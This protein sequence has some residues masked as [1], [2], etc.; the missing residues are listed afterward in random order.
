M[1]QLIAISSPKYCII[2]IKSIIYRLKS[3][4]FGK[5][6]ITSFFHLFYMLA[7]DAAVGDL[8]DIYH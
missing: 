6:I 1:D 4:V 8:A 2:I 3:H 5:F 7:S